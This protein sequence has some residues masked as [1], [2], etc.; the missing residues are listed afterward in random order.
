MLAGKLDDPPPV[1]EEKRARKDEQRVRPLG[2]HRP[3]RGVV[4]AVPSLG[5]DELDAERRRCFLR[6]LYLDGR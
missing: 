5:D 2:H 4:V 3:K 6:L 1:A